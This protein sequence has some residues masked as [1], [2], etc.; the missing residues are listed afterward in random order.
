MISTF[1]RGF[2]WRALKKYRLPRQTLGLKRLWCG[3][4][5]I[6]PTNATHVTEF[7]SGVQKQVFW[8][9]TA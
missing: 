6:P 4:S 2:L 5:A 8:F 7:F 9:P 1:C 3:G